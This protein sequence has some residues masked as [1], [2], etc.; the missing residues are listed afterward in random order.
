MNEEIRDSLFYGIHNVLSRDKNAIVLTADHGAHGLTRIQTDYP[1]QY[2]NVG[3]AEQNMINVAA[4][5][6]LCGKKVFVYAIINFVV[7]RCLDQLNIDVSAMKSNVCIIGAGP[8]FT[9]SIDGPTHHGIQD[10]AIMS[11]L[12]NMTIFNVTD[13]IMAY[14]LPCNHFSGPT[15][16]R[17]TKGTVPRV[18]NIDSTFHDGIQQL[19]TGSDIA[20]VSSGQMVHKAISVANKL[21]DIGH[22]AGVLDVYRIKPINS[23]LLLDNIKKYNR[24]VVLE[25]NISSGGLGEKICTILKD[26]HIPI[27]LF[28]VGDRYGFYYS[29]VKQVEEKYGLSEECILNGIL[30]WI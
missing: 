24:V 4:G 20:I 9:Y 29:S 18:Y 16:F 28:S 17:L 15:Y 13:S 11:A 14:A 1:E 26:R 22:N 3:V 23:N 6:S 25:D 19:I 8:G 7:L 21:R 12:P 27:K 30:E 2:I 5:L 10:V